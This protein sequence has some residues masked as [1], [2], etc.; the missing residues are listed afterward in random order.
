VT[1]LVGCQGGHFFCS[2]EK[3]K[4][5]VI[6]LEH[7][8]VQTFLFLKKNFYTLQARESD[9]LLQKF[10]GVCSKLKEK[11]SSISVTKN[12]STMLML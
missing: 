10:I 8:E 6:E 11:V 9:Q 1:D 3:T 4:D 2:K 5:Q 12:S 7:V